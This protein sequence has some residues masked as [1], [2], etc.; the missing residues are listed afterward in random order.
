MNDKLNI[1]L[2]CRRR[3]GQL[4]IN[5]RPQKRTILAAATFLLAPPATPL[6]SKEVKQQLATLRERDRR[7]PRERSWRWVAPTVKLPKSG[8]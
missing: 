8:A 1:K 6:L 2:K 7:R 5:R 3:K 4:K